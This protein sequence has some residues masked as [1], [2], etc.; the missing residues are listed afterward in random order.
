MHART[1]A[2][3]ALGVASLAAP[4]AAQSN[5]Y[6]FGGV[7]TGGAMVPPTPTPVLGRAQFTLDLPTSSLVY[8]VETLLPAPT[9]V[10]VH[11]RP[12]SLRSR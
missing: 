2:I 11:I 6:T 1:L 3:A 7:M 9:M 4:S 10:T 8:R 12:S 5:H